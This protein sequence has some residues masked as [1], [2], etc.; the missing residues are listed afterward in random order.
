MR[1]ITSQDPREAREDE[2]SVPGVEKMRVS[3]FEALAERLGFEPGE[4]LERLS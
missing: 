1:E 4:L 2:P 3:E